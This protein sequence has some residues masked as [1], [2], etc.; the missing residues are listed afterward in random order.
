MMIGKQQVHFDLPIQVPFK[1]YQTKNVYDL[2]VVQE[3]EEH[4][5]RSQRM[6]IISWPLPR[7]V[8]ENK[9]IGILL[10]PWLFFER[11]YEWFIWLFSSLF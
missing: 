9:C 3:K 10:I 8:D 1:L 11:I 6:V 7:L 4:L 2:V 5:L